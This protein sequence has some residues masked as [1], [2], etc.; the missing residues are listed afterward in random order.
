MYGGLTC[1]AEMTGQGFCKPFAEEENK[2]MFSYFKRKQAVT[3]AVHMCSTSIANLIALEDRYI[4]P[5]SI[6]CDD[7][8]LGF[9]QQLVLYAILLS[10]NG[11]DAS[12]SMKLSITRE[13][14]KRLAPSI[15]KSIV[16][17]LAELGREAH[18]GHQHYIIRRDEGA[19][20]IRALIKKDQNSANMHLKGFRNYI[21]RNYI[22]YVPG[23]GQ[24]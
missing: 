7:Y 14:Y 1:F 18:P 21:Y 22:G 3:D 16:R 15:G 23:Q 20:Y 19:G 6:Y 8:V 4:D 2:F 24:P 11:K 12:L 5:A 9:H 13:I 10:W 17:I